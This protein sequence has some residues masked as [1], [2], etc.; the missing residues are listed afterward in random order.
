MKTQKLTE[1][2]YIEERLINDLVF[3]KTFREAR[4]KANG[5]KM[6]SMIDI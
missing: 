4:R 5:K 2:H 6:Q 1:E 3:S